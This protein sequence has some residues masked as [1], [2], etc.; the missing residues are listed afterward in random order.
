MKTENRARR[1]RA[2][3]RM[4]M[5]NQDVTEAMTPGL[6]YAGKPPEELS[7]EDLIAAVKHFHS[8]HVDSHARMTAMERR[9]SK[10]EEAV[11]REKIKQLDGWLKAHPQDIRR[12]DGAPLYSDWQRWGEP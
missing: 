4:K 12:G 5:S 7:H 2:T 10:L 1:Y 3:R 8:A 9:M 11:P 6:V